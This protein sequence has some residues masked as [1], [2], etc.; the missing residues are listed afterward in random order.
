[1]FALLIHEI[2]A[3]TAGLV[4]ALELILTLNFLKSPASLLALNV[5]SL[6]GIVHNFFT[7]GQ[8]SYFE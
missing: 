8:I 3:S 7:F 6:K 2:C 1:M 4:A 5:L